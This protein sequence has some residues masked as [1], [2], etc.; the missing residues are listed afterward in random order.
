MSER[1][2]AVSTHPQVASPRTTTPSTLT[3]RSVLQLFALCP[4]VPACEFADVF[5]RGGGDTQA[6]F[7]LDDPAFQAL[8]T[9]GGMACG[10]A[11]EVEVLLIRTSEAE[12]VALERYCPHEGL[13]MAPCDNNPRPGQLSL[14]QGRL[15]CVWH[16]SIFDLDGQRVS[17][18]SPRDLQRFPVTFDPATGRAE[19]V[20]PRPAGPGGRP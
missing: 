11:G 8:A 14:D 6:G 13:D 19:I 10:R 20:L 7:S 5:V 2:P 1:K 16:N 12:I 18:P 17:G 9:L 15:R 4:L 3:R